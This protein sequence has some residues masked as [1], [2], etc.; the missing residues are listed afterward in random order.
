MA[1][2]ANSTSQFVLQKAGAIKISVI[3]YIHLQFISSII[4]FSYCVSTLSVCNCED[5][6]IF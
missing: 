3:L 1:H 6:A 5:L 4:L 2:F